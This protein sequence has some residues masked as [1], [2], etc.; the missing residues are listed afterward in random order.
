MAGDLVSSVIMADKNRGMNPADWH[1][2]Y[3]QQSQWTE[4]IRR[5]L[6]GR[7]NPEKGDWILEVGAGTGAVLDQVALDIPSQVVGIDLDLESLRFSQGIDRTLNL[8]QADVRCL[9][10][11]DAAFVITYC[12]YL[13][14]WVEDPLKALIEMRRVTRFGG[15]VIALAESDFAARIDFP[16]PLD[17]LGEMQ[18]QAL[19]AQG[20]DIHMGRKLGNLFYQ[21]GLSDIEVGILGA[22]WHFGP[23]KDVD[24]TEWS[25]L[26][27]DLSH[28]LSEEE[29]TEYRRIEHQAVKKGEKV[30]FIPTFFA[31]GTV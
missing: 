13:L 14:M 19:L 8:A 21:S 29:F 5:R 28:V 9:P 22:Q 10:F 27:A 16:P 7:T 20:A 17:E 15:N 18:T 11:R 30:L 26:Q 2:R 1:K 31:I 12:H 4:T 3:L 6:F 25:T 24:Q 23:D